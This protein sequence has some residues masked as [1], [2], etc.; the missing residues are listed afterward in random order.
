MLTPV[1]VSTTNGH[2]SILQSRQYTRYIPGKSHRILITGNFAS[3]ANAEMAFVL[4]S[5][6][7][8]S[9]DD[10]VVASA[11]WNG[12]DA[13]WLRTNFDPT[14][15]QIL[16]IDAQMLYAGRVRV[17]FDIC[18]MD[19]EAHEFE[20]A[21]EQ[22]LPTMQSFN[23]PVRI[24]HRNTGAA[25]SKARVGYFETGNGVFFQTTRAVA[26]GTVNFLCCSVQSEGGAES[27]GFPFSASNGVTTIGVTTR[28]P[29]LSIRPSRYYMG[30]DN[31]AHL[32][33]QDLAISASSNMAHWELVI[34]GTLT[35][36]SWLRV[37][38]AVTAGAFVTGV[39]YV[40]LTVGTTDFTL[41]GAAS[42]TV[43]L[44]F[45]ASGAGAGTGTATREESVAEYDVSATAISGGIAVIRGDAAS[46]TGSSRSVT[47]GGVDFRNPLTLS[48]ID[49][50][51]A[52]QTNVSLVCTSYS[53]TSTVSGTF[54]WHEQSI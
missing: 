3:G 18:G 23:L 24:E 35:G 54:N 2:Y 1:T 33:L 28:R 11:D 48:L 4:R 40:I 19:Y 51:T 44:S 13:D 22:I 7:S 17:G 39:R 20:I 47:S 29:I 32:E 53:A 14:M 8:G 25:E 16:W 37:G 27:R 46:G 49:A 6:C 43:G 26:G 52:T 45:V 30:R 41:I 9:V 21:N 10:S 42:N 36:A 15:I 31:R 38:T 12:K 5:S 34:G 50:L